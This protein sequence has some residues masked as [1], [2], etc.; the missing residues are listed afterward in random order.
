MCGCVLVR[1]GVGEGIGG[2]GR[3]PGGRGAGWQRSMDGRAYQGRGIGAVEAEEGDRG[4]D[5]VAAGG[6]GGVGAGLGEG[7]SLGDRGPRG[8]EQC[9]SRQHGWM[10]DGVGRWG[11]RM[12]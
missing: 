7:G 4:Q 6:G 11:P 12:S 10:G 3:V 1:D 8:A 5:L 2:S 9:L